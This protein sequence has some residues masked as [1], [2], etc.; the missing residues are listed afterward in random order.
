MKEIQ[1][2]FV[3]LVPTAIPLDFRADLELWTKKRT[4][5][6]EGVLE[7]IMASIKNLGDELDL[8]LGNEP[9]DHNEL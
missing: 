2:E 7:D 3:H 8:I 6:D 1:K 4:D 5:H 9:E